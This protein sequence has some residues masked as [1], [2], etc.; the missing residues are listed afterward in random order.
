MQRYKWAI[1]TGASGGIG[2]AIC[3][4]LIEN[5]VNVIGVARNRERLD[6]LQSKLES[7]CKS[8]SF[9]PV[10]CDLTNKE[11][12]LKFFETVE[13]QFGGVN[14]LI[15]NA[16]VVFGGVSILDESGDDRAIEQTIETNFTS[17]VRCSKLA[18]RCMRKR[19]EP[20]YIINISSVLGHAVPNIKGHPLVNVYPCTKFA[21]TALAQIIQRE[22]A[23][24][25]LQHI[26]ISNISPGVVRTAIIDSANIPSTANLSFLEPGDIAEAVIYI[27]KSAQRVQ[28]QDIIIKPNGERF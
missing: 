23:H 24:F 8:A 6:A 2:A 5:S 11:E 25:K 28:V 22:L 3:Q 26:R 18:I 13:A 15:N 7:I 10:T 14:I 9:H 12:L 27:L 17:V 4:A 16:G 19:H 20:G 1:V 21:L